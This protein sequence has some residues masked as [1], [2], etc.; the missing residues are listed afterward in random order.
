MIPIISYGTF[1][2]KNY[3]SSGF[4]IGY[5][6]DEKNKNI[7]NNEL[8]LEFPKNPDNFNGNNN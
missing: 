2:M 7:K 6:F 8:F 3:I 4:F 5:E 1:K